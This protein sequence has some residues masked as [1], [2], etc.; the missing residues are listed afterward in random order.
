LVC[1]VIRAAE[2]T[3]SPAS[4]GTFYRVHR[5]AVAMSGSRDERDPEKTGE[6]EVNQAPPVVDVIA[7]DDPDEAANKVRKDQPLID[8]LRDNQRET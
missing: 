2:T 1:I 7:G 5:G 8:I 6:T 3:G 4:I